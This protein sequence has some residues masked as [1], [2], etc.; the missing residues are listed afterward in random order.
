ME[1]LGL[2]YDLKWYQRKEDRLA[3]DEYLALYPTA[4]P[5]KE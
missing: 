1:E 4:T 5:P 3:P 2:P